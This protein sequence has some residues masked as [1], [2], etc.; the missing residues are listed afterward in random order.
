MGYWARIGGF[1]GRLTLYVG[2][3]LWSTWPLAQSPCTTLPRGEL[4]VI[5][6]PLLN[7]WTFW[8][9]AE[10]AQH[11]FHGYWEAE[12]FS[13]TKHTFAFSEPQ[14]VSLLVAPVFW[15]SGSRILAYNVYLWLSLVLNAWACE[16]LL[17]FLGINNWVSL[18]G[19]SQL[20]LLPIVHWQLDVIQLV[21]LWGVLWTLLSLWRMCRHPGW[22][23]GFELGTAF[24]L[25]FLASGHQGLLWALVLM[26][27]WWAFPFPYRRLR[28][29]LGGILALVVAG[30]VVG[31]MALPMRRA[32]AEHGFSRD[33]QTM[34]NLSAQLVDYL[35]SPGIVRIPQKI[36][37]TREGWFLSPG[38]IK[39]SLALLGIVWGLCRRR[40]RR[41]AFALLVVGVVSLLLSLG[42]SLQIRGCVPWNMLVAYVPGVAQVRNVFRFAFFVQVVVILQAAL[43]LHGGLMWARTW[44]MRYAQVW[45]GVLLLLGGLAGVEVLPKTPALGNAPDISQNQGWIQFLK[46]NATP[47]KA[48]LCLPMPFDS[49]VEQYEKEAR[50]MYF[51][52][53]HRVPLLNGYSGFFPQEY[54]DTQAL[55]N[56]K[57][58]IPEVLLKLHYLNVEYIVIDR[59][60]LPRSWFQGVVAGQWRV[61]RVLEDPSGIDIYRLSYDGVL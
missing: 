22:R 31:S 44:S 10:R 49:S 57:F 7:S 55:V 11:G 34:S 33:T 35:A 61:I 25:T 50:W 30:L 39:L 19:A 15:L 26:G 47:G 32:L 6:V 4:S 56:T 16:R 46:T 37:A 60:Q 2:L 38:W 52:S 24:G 29:W 21:P 54:F 8:W 48:V 3:A 28:F 59:Q 14:P 18:W 12:I 43:A 5:T 58:P 45:T 23:A 41:W 53:E 20:L 40:W 36:F 27:S 51:A 17:R 13:P 42:P 9:N 1:L